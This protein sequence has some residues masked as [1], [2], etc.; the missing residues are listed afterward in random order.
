[1]VRW[2]YR[3]VFDELEDMRNYLEVLN[4]QIY[5]TNS[6][7]LLP[8]AG[9]PTLTM[10]S[11]QPTM[12]PVEVSEKDDE[13]VITVE[14]MAGTTKQEIAL[15]LITPRALEIT[16]EQTEERIGETVG[17]YLHERRSGSMTQAVSLPEPVTDAG[18]S[19]TFKNGV[20]EVHLK[21]I[22]KEPGRKIPVD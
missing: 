19:A 1:M 11:A 6:A 20:L 10:L 3:S 9:E 18:S 5:G 7:T 15:D 21:K 13:L 16:C 17:C 2:Y 8:A 4:R 14:M 12:L 22:R